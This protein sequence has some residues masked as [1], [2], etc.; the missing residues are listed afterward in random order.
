MSRV[1]DI[2][3]KVIPKNVADRFVKLN[4]YSG[5]VDPRSN[6]HFGC[7]LN[8]VL[9]G[10]LQYGISIDKRKCIGFV[11]GTKWNEFI[12]LNRMA[13]DKMMPKNS[14]SRVLSI[15]FKLIKKNAPHIKWI[16]SY[17]DATQSG[18][19]TIYRA[20]GFILTQIN[21]NKSIVKMPNG[22]VI[23]KIVLEPSFGGG[24]KGGLKKK[25]GKVGIYDGWTSNK[26]IKYIGGEFLKGFQLRYIYF[27]HPEERKNLTVP[28]IPFSKID[29]MGAGMYKGKKKCDTGNENSNGNALWWICQS[30]E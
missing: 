30:Y 4:H 10:V 25:H 16:L 7:F 18:D 1:K 6:L 26:Y 8:G 3:L 23:C 5:K 12:E 15:S 27:L 13:F 28:E 9:H 2:R 19:G 20:S 17:A 14:A 21:E 29:E 11:K 24:A 22:D